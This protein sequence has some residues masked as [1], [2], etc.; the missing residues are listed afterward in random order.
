MPDLRPVFF[1]VG[2]MVA[3]LGLFMFVPMLVDL[4]MEKRSWPAFAMSGIITTLAGGVMALAGYTPN[5]QIRARGAFVLTAFS[6]ALLSLFAAVPFLMDPMKLS[7]TD[8]IFEATS[9]ITTTGSTILTGLDDLPEGILMWRA[10]LQW[11]GGIGIIATAMAILPM[12]GV[13]GMQLFKDESNDISEKIL[14]RPTKVA[15]LIGG[16]YLGLTL[17]CAAGYILTGM[18]VFDA[19][20]HAMTTLA[21]G[22]YST[23]DLSMGGFMDNGADIVCMVFMLAGA[24]PF[25]I[26]M[27]MFSGK[28]DAPLYDPQVRTFLLIIL[29][30][31]LMISAGLWMTSDLPQIR[32]FRLAAFNTI[33][34]VTG[35]GYASADYNSWGP[36]AVA[37]FFVFMFIGG[38]AGSTACSVKIFRYQVAFEAFRVYLIHMPRPNTVIPMR[39][40]GKP[41]SDAVVY[42][43]MSYFFL[44]F[45]TFAATAMILSMIGLDAMTAWSGAG[46]AVANVGPGLGDIIGPSGTYQSLPGSAKWVLL[47]AMIV[48]RLE[49]ITALV[50]LTPSF[51]RA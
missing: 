32:A 40:G 38:C 21:T 10:I 45:M 20:A 35:T 30:L 46:S 13:G 24:L 34:V 5:M 11:I 9:G 18:S 16:T 8:A 23:S 12:L 41:L 29:T 14:V 3:G 42:S 1:I 37:S 49:I 19:F 6:W 7:L 28:F 48:G 26:Y 47:T 2:L 27:L 39:Y 50:V 43:V 31:T 4:A 22:G 15:L 17:M 51:W 36:F 33:S 25:G 44:F